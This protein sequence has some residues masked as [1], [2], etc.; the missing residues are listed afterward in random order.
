MR[1]AEGTLAIVLEGAFVRCVGRHPDV[2]VMPAARF[3]SAKLGHRRPPRQILAVEG[4]ADHVALLLGREAQP[5]RFQTAASG[6]SSV[7]SE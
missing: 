7:I 5:D 2:Q 3:Q 1:V 4:S 6:V